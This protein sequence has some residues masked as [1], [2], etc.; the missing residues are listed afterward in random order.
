[1]VGLEQSSSAAFYVLSAGKETSI[2]SVV[3]RKYETIPL[4][5]QATPQTLTATA[6]QRE[7]WQGLEK[8]PSSAAFYVLLQGTETRMH[9]RPHHIHT[10]SQ[11][12]MKTFPVT[13]R[14][15]Q[16]DI[17]WQ[18]YKPSSAPLY[19]SGKNEEAR[20]IG[21]SASKGGMKN[22]QVTQQTFP[23]AT[24]KGKKDSQAAHHTLLLFT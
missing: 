3:R 6:G 17:R 7:R 24:V 14:Q 9:V 2:T 19:V 20:H 1:M 15:R 23:A 16:K 8:D 11:T 13:T 18:G 10:S 12:N 4:L 22:I 21:Y 5:S